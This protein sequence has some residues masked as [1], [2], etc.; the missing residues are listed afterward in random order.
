MWSQSVFVVAQDVI[1]GVKLMRS[2]FLSHTFFIQ[3]RTPTKSEPNQIE[4][5]LNP[6]PFETL[7]SIKFYTK[8]A[9]FGDFTVY[10]IQGKTISTNTWEKDVKILQEVLNSTTQKYKQR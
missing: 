4:N 9:D 7:T 2:L 5:I 3:P 8:E 10:N 1:K 6:N